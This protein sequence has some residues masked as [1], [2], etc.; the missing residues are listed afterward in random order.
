MKH[1][2]YFILTRQEQGTSISKWDQKYYKGVGTSDTKE[3]KKYFKAIKTHRKSFIWG[4]QPD[5]DALEMA[6]DG[7]TPSVCVFVCVIEPSC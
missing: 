6:F 2:T 4:G 5:G 1:E 3:A 7:V